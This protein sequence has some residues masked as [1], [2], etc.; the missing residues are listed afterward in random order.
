M[1]DYADFEDAVEDV[2]KAINEGQFLPKQRASLVALC[3]S[4]RA[5]FEEMVKAQPKSERL[6]M[7]GIGGTGDESTNPDAELQQRIDQLIKE[8]KDM[9][10]GTAYTKVLASDTALAER[11]NK[12]HRRLM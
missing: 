4:D 5:N 12:V 11:Y 9:S 2:S 7:V 1:R 8:N 6:S 10:Y 3:L